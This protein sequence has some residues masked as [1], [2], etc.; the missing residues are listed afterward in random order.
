MTS[1]AREWGLRTVPRSLEQKYLSEGWWN[2]GSL[3]SVIA[4]AIAEQPTQRMKIRSAVRPWKGT[5]DE[6][7]KEAQH[8]AGALRARGIG[9]GDV[10]ALQLPN[11]KEAA[12]SFWA[13]AILGATVT[14]IVHFYGAKEVDYILRR[15][16]V[17]ALVTADRFG[18]NDYLTT[19]DTV[20][21]QAPDLEH[22]IVLSEDPL[23]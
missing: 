11:W 3:G 9:A 10:V 15:T 19:V 18:C 22:V 20:R 2:E 7:L 17:R 12:V 1:P 5:F 6:V 13:A 8:L 16:R 4:I 21:S 23:P 14:P